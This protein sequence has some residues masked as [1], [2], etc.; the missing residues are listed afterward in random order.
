MHL[1]INKYLCIF[2]LFVGNVVFINF[3]LY[4]LNHVKISSHAV[5]LDGISD[6][7][8]TSCFMTSDGADVGGR[9][10]KRVSYIRGQC[11]NEAVKDRLQFSQIKNT[12]WPWI[13]V[14]RKHRT[15]YC[16]TPKVGST[17]WLKVFSVLE[18]KFNDTENSAQVHN[19]PLLLLSYLNATEREFV[20]TNYTKFMVIREPF[21]RILSAYRD[22]F[23]PHAGA[24]IPMFRNLGKKIAA[25]Y[26]EDDAIPRDLKKYNKLAQKITP[27]FQEFLQYVVDGNNYVIPTHYSEPRHWQ[28][29]I[30]LC[31]P[32]R[33]NYDYVIDMKYAEEEANFVLK[34]A[35]VPPEIRYPKNLNLPLDEMSKGDI[36]KRY[37]ALPQQFYSKVNPKIVND[38]YHYYKCDYDMFGFPPPPQ[39]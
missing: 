2:I 18:G 10:K 8:S 15:L 32:C 28:R 17:N 30:D 3:L 29:Q 4:K 31:Y 13:Y 11:E 1:F 34:S 9:I 24:G 27:S 25:R 35:G 37:Q 26:R 23:L 21:Q 5:K 7:F 16:Q 39:F 36:A 33:I 19:V 12:E 20:L 14:S 22:K 6:Y 38:L